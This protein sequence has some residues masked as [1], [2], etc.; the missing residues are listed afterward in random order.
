MTGSAAQLVVLLLLVV[1]VV[2][3]VVVVDVVV[4][5]VDVAVVVVATLI[6]VSVLVEVVLDGSVTGLGYL[7]GRPRFG[8]G[9]ATSGGRQVGHSHRP[10]GMERKPTQNV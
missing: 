6:V 2:V 9:G 10:A 3:V 8:L 1:V 4:V 5:A 7:N